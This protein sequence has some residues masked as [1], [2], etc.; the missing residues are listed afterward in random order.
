[1]VLAGGQRPPSQA[2][3]PGRPRLPVR[4]TNNTTA[5]RRANG[6]FGTL[7]LAQ[8]FWNSR[9]AEGPLPPQT[10]L[11]RFRLLDAEWDSMCRI[12]WERG[13]VLHKWVTFGANDSLRG[14]QCSVTVCRYSAQGPQYGPV[15]GHTVE[16]DSGWPTEDGHR[17]CRI[18]A[19]E[20]L[21]RIVKRN[22]TTEG[23]LGS[24]TC[25]CLRWWCSLPVLNW[26]PNNQVVYSVTGFDCRPYHEVPPSS[27]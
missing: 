10:V 17:E 23:D 3:K 26:F 21:K 1:M 19:G 13:S 14:G 22:N 15:L 12:C 18:M 4:H 16:W 2:Y 5:T 11:G 6:N 25:V 8:G 27:L 24:Y 7:F 9:R 20:R